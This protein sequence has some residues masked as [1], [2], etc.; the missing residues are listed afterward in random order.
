MNQ[1]FIYLFTVLFLLNFEATF[2]QSSPQE[3]TAYVGTYTRDEGFVDGQAEGIY[4]VHQNL[5]SGK[6]TLGKTVA[7]IVNPSYVLVS[8]DK[9]NLYAVSE[10]SNKEGNSGEVYSYKINR[11]D[12][13]TELGKIS[14]EAFAPAHLA[15]DKTGQYIFVSNYVG[16]VM[17]LYKRQAD[18]N[19]KVQQKVS[20]KNPSQ[21]HAHSV[22]ISADNSHVYI[23]DLGND[24]IWIYNFDA[25]KGSLTPN[26][27]KFVSVKKGAGPRHTAFSKNDRF[28]YVVNELNSSVTVFNVKRKGG[29][30]NIQHIST[31]PK[32]YRGK[33]SGAEIEVGASGKYLYVSNRGANNIVE[34][35]I[36]AK[37][38]KLAVIGFTPTQG[39][40][41]RFFTISPDGKFLYAANQDSSSISQFSINASSGKLKSIAEPLQIKTPVCIEFKK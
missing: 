14:T 30:K 9:K 41:P 39:K 27:Q 38:G 15:T 18:G 23:A 4:T 20:L 17:L 1:K 2:A 13:L 6:L 21:S 28:L 35:K 3:K 36:N 5:E 22:N 8:K 10:L 24:K 25:E 11:D 26:K 29:L 40:F 34:Y 32:E 33:N 12:S 19:L 7:K 31:L 16:G 37:N